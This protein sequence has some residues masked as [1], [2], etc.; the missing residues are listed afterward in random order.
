LQCFHY[1]ENCFDKRD[2][3]EAGK[4]FRDLELE[5]FGILIDCGKDLKGKKGIRKIGSC[6]VM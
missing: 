2:Y 3:S 5:Y 1:T 6:L 4:V